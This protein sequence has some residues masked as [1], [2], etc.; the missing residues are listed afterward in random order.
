MTPTLRPYQS[1]FSVEIDA[2]WQMGSRN[3]LGVLPTGAG[4]THTFSSKLA[5][6]RGASVAIA[7]RQELVGQISLSLARFGL[8]HRIIGPRPIIKLILEM[9]GDELGTTFYDPN[10]PVAVAGVNTLVR[11]KDDLKAWSQQVGLW[12]QDEVHHL[13][14]DNIW[15]KAIEMFPNAKG[16]GVT[17]TP[18]RADGKGLGAHADGVLHSV[19]E[20]PSMREL[21]DMGFLADYRIFAPP[22]DL[23]VSGVA[24]A[25]DGDYNK[26]QL[27]EAVHHSHIVGDVVGHYLKIAPGKLGVTFA[28][29][30][31]TAT[32]IAGQ[33]NA[34]GVRAEVVSAKTPDKIRNE[35]IR[36]FRNGDIKQLV[37]VDLFGEGFDLPAIE[38]VSMARPT[39]SY[40][41]FAQQFGR[42]LRPVPGKS[43]G[44]II[45]HVGNTMRHGLPDAVRNWTLDARSRQSR[46]ARDPD[47]VPVTTCT[48]CFRVYEAI[49]RDCPFCGHVQLVASRSKPEYVDGDL[50]E[51]TP[52]ALDALR[53]RVAESTRTPEALVA[54]FRAQGFSDKIIGVNAARQR[55]KL[56]ALDELREAIAWWAGYQRA[57]DR[58]DTESY[59][60]FY[61]KFGIDVMTAQTLKRAEMIDLTQRIAACLPQGVTR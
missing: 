53:Q 38:V 37:N 14:R 32:E 25:K 44:L 61:H 41:V 60:R 40:A 18:E 10:S 19:V 27:R 22:S 43:H 56:T 6:H 49:R 1:A 52:E 48:S 20:G 16:L 45:D 31:E 11:R 21:I 5:A 17:A 42:G 39:Q 47:V 36:R 23:D 50:Y 54:D 15:G 57:H 35:L 30:V 24:L 12:V 26:H 13:L 29:D 59:R 58:P 8:R 4:K 28:T 51:L 3:V 9:Q 2:H 34:A 7:H 33:Y 55:Q 46:A